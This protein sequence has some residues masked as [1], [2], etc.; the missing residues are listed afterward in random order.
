MS[1]TPS[2][3]SHSAASDYRWKHGVV[4]V[5]GLIGG[6]GGGKSQ[7]AALLGARGAFVIDA[8]AVGHEVLELP[9]VRQQVVAR[10]GSRAW[11]PSEDEGRVDRR[12]LGALVFADSAALRD[13]EAILH[14]RM[15]RR[16]EQTILRE[17]GQ[18]LA[19]AVVLD[20]AILLEAG[21]D[22]L[23]DLVVYVDTPRA[24]RLERVSRQRGWTEETLRSREAAQWPC[25]T[26]RSR[27]DVVIANEGDLQRLELD[28][29]SFW[30]TITGARG[31]RAGH[32]PPVP[33]AGEQISGLRAEA[34]RL[35]PPAL[36][37]RNV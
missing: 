23:C 20:A 21:W 37:A 33:A 32:S 11:K 26:K 3:V 16:F 29:E 18:G 6:I 17:V 31:G 19:R 34:S 4:P 27:A 13:L 28:V 30:R 22:D 7:V 1:S 2:T 36:G 25:E 14:P 5:L 8:D 24:V 9:E 35:G 10:F 15:R 12:V